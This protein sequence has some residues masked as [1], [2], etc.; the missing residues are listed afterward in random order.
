V[1]A[2][3]GVERGGT[4][5]GYGTVS[6]SATL[7]GDIRA[8]TTAGTLSFD[9]P[10]DLDGSTFYWR[11]DALTDNAT[12]QGT[13]DWNTLAFSGTAKLGRPDAPLSIFL[14]FADGISPQS[15]NSFWN[16]PHTWTVFGMNSQWSGVSSA[17]NFSF[18][19]GQFGFFW[20]SMNGAGLLAFAPVP[21]PSTCMMA[22]AGLACGGYLVR[23]HR[24]R[25]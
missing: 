7:R 17:G 20:D 11:L 24:K 5:E 6:G 1:A 10:A 3:S 13:P 25:A 8:G 15:G 16:S 9:G 14:E 2:P 19:E 21:E 23:R 4:I 18:A 22:L 12:S